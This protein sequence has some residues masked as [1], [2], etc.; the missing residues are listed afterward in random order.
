MGQFSTV[1][2]WNA[3]DN[4]DNLR[5]ECMI[6]AICLVYHNFTYYV[7]SDRG[8]VRNPSKYVL[9]SKLDAHGKANAIHNLTDSTD[10]I[11]KY[12]LAV[13]LFMSGVQRLDGACE[14]AIF[15]PAQESA[16]KKHRIGIRCAESV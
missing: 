15:L 4:V 11:K 16:D 6:C 7:T 14:R 5:A 10:Y 1:F 13:K 2:L 12:G 3:V 9:T 8:D